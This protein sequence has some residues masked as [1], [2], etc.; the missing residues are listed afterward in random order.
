MDRVALVRSKFDR[1]KQHLRD[2]DA[3]VRAFLDAKPYVVSA[4]RD[5][6]TRGPTYFLASVAD[7]PIQ[8]S[9]IAG[10]VLH[11]LRS[12]L[13]HLAYQLVMVA[14]HDPPSD[15]VYFPISGSAKQY[16]ND[17]RGKV[18]GMRDTAINAIDALTPY[19][20]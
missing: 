10:D 2:L 11:N 19:K 8:L 1:A 5:P 14:G 12:A 4:R 9:S 7:P 13:D 3:A 6:S 17:S 18:K 15:H 20:G 16:R